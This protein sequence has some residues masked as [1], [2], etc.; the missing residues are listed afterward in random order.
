MPGGQPR[1]KNKNTL[2]L[3]QNQT[4][5][6]ISMFD[7]GLHVDRNQELSP[8]DR[9]LKDIFNS[10]TESVLDCEIDEDCRTD[11]E[12]WSDDEEFSQ[13]LA[14]MAYKLEVDDSKDDDWIPPRLR[15]K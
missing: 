8:D 10:E 3:K 2:G 4:L 1:K 14:E 11:E 15:R 13:R 9:N 12:E 5:Q 7:E 6:S